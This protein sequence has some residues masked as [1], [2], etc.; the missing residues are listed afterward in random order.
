M[1]NHI[2]KILLTLGGILLASAAVAATWQTVQIDS[3]GNMIW[4]GNLNASGT[5]TQNGTAVGFGTVTTSSA[6]TTNA[7]PLWTSGS[8]LGNSQLAQAAGGITDNGTQIIDGGGN[9]AGNV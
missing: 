7:L 2:T 9:W 5:I 8:A 6:G 3:N 4:G 1:K